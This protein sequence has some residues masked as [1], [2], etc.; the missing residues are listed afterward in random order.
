MVDKP[1]R[2]KKSKVPWGKVAGIVA[3]AIVVIGV[4]YYVYGTYIFQPPPVYA[5][6]GT[7]LGYFDIELYPSCAP[8][9]VA[10]FVDL[11][12]SG[13]YDNLVWH[14][15][16]PGFVIQTGDPNSR[17]GLNSTRSTWG[18]GGSSQT[19]PLEWCGWLHNYAGYLAMAHQS[20]NVNSGTSQYYVNLTNDS[21]YQLDG[22]YTVFAKVI[23]GMNVV[24]AISHVPT[25]NS[26]NAQQPIN[27][28]YMT[29][30]TI[31]SAAAAPSPQPITNCPKTG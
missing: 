23:T 2:R 11:A 24:C 22:N 10:N 9:T 1:G 16:V 3:A 6:I 26:V 15:L 18:T 8:K 7:S 5:K 30:V 14:R 12:K 21:Y 13:F 4:G 17:N 19:V 31:I 27:P 28:V 29:N 20:G 25:Y